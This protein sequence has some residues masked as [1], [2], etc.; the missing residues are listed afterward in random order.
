MWLYC[1]GRQEKNP[2][3][4]YVWR[5]KSLFRTKTPRQ[6]L[7][8]ILL[9]T[10]H[11]IV[12]RSCP[13]SASFKMPSAP[14]NFDQGLLDILKI[15]LKS[16]GSHLNYLYMAFL[17]LMSMAIWWQC[18]VTWTHNIYEDVRP[19]TTTTKRKTTHTADDKKNEKE[20]TT[21]NPIF[22][23]NHILVC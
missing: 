8:I 4:A 23:T 3:I 20:T 13:P 12:I 11:S 17:N 10:F 6:S 14:V 18:A 22:N 19:T 5:I 7:V 1:I 16:I 15:K 2:R 21:N 9:S